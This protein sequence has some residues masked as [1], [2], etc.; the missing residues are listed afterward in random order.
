MLRFYLYRKKS[1]KFKYR[2]YYQ[3]EQGKSHKCLITRKGKAILILVNGKFIKV[4]NLFE[5]HRKKDRKTIYINVGNGNVQYRKEVGTIWLH[6]GSQFS[7]FR[8]K[9]N[10]PFYKAI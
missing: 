7:L 6:D 10:Q 4:G 2:G 3:D 9:R 5:I 8:V 1:G